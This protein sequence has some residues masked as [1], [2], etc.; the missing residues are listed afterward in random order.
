MSMGHYK[1]VSVHKRMLVVFAVAVVAALSMSS[2]AMAATTTVTYKGQGFNADGTL[3]TNR[4]ATPDN[5]GIPGVVL[6][7]GQQYMLFVLTGGPSS[8]SVTLNLPDG[9]HQMVKVGGTWKYVSTTIFTKAQLTALPAT[10]TFSGAP[11]SNPQLVISHGCTKVGSKTTTAIHLKG[12]DTTDVTGTHQPLGSEIHDSAAVTVDGGIAIPATSTV[13]F[14]FYNSIDCTGDVAESTSK[15]AAASVDPALLEGPLHAGSYSYKATF[16]TPADS[17]VTG[18]SAACE[19]ITIDKG[20]LKI[21]TTIHDKD[22]GA[23]TSVALGSVVHDTATVTTPGGSTPGFA[24][25][26]VSFTLNGNAVA[27]GAGEAGVT[28]NSEDSAP[29]AA[30]S[31]TYKASVAGNDDYNGAT[32]DDEPLEVKKAQLNIVTTI[33]NAAHSAV[34]S[35]FSG[36]VV[37]DT[38]TVTGQV[39]GFAP[40]GAISFTLNGNPVANDPSADGSATARSV[41]SA[42]LTAGNYTYNASIAGDSNYEGDTSEDEPLSVKNGTFC[43]PGFWKNASDAAWAKTGYSRTD[44]FNDTVAAAGFYPEIDPDQTLDYVINN[45]NLYGQAGQYNLTGANA[46]G[47]FLSSQIPGFVWNGTQVDTCPLS[48][49]GSF[50]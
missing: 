22:H 32:S 42:P 4:C 40:T 31:Y 24:I 1:E 2:V 27:N 29:L 33:H 15:P 16:V 47:A 17:A 20:D 7:P 37:H 49:N 18:S 19:S 10:A 3:T 44:S 5:G 6:Q 41:D 23:V 34:T 45:N 28:A 36:S 21:V 26:A 50:K 11:G 38:A 35:V 14:K 9:P 30:G 12:D 13:E 48:N 39:S 43:S 46:V 8:G 25:G